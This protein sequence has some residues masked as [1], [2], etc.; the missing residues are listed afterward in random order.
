MRVLIACEYS[1]IV[2]DEFLWKGHDAFSCDILPTESKLTKDRHFQ[3]NIF[4]VIYDNWD[5]VIAHPPCTRLCVSGARWKYEK[6]N[7]DQEQNEAKDFFMKFTELKCKWAIENP[8]G[9]MSTYWRKPDQII[10]PWQFGHEERKPICLWLNNLPKLK[11]TKIVED[12]GSRIHLMAPSANRG[13]ERSRF[14]KGIAAAM[15]NQWGILK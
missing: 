15:A 1:G 7:W 13:K 2:R 14:Y 3:C 8:I 6:P 10:Q 11:P 9:I 4:D 5:L 12:K